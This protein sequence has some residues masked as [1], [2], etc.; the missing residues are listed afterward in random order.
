NKKI[1]V[2]PRLA[3]YHEHVDDH[4]VEIANKFSDKNY[5]I[6]CT[7]VDELVVA[8]KKSKSFEPRPFIL[9]NEKFV[10]NIRNFIES[11]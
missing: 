5:V 11:R 9:N 10:D 8:I 6:K 4:Q 2:F 7:N 3:E 1:I